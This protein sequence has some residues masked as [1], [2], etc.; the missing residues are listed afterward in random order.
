MLTGITSKDI[1][2]AKPFDEVLAL[3]CQQRPLPPSR[4]ISWA[5]SLWP[6]F[7]DDLRSLLGD[8]RILN[9][10]LKGLSMFFYQ[11]QQPIK[12]PKLGPWWASSMPFWKMTAETGEAAAQREADLR[13]AEGRAR[14]RCRLHDREGPSVFGAVAQPRDVHFSDACTGRGPHRLRRSAGGSGGCGA[15]GAFVRG[16]CEYGQSSGKTGMVE[17]LGRIAPTTVDSFS[18][19]LQIS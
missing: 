11:R 6:V 12:R 17:A 14:F 2:K 9:L 19:A 10:F 16:E 8:R 1:R 3:L 5:G 4:I 7:S 13:A 18:P 15:E